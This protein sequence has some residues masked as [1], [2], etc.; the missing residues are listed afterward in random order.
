MVQ[1]PFQ[2]TTTAWSISSKFSPRSSR[3]FWKFLR[4][5]FRY[6]LHLYIHKPD[7]V[8]QMMS[9]PSFRPLDDHVSTIVTN[10]YF[11]G[12]MGR[13]TRRFHLVLFHSETLFMSTLLLYHIFLLRTEC[14]S[15]III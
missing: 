2:L 12:V 6:I 15:A 10:G 5:E 7:V 13:P 4:S 11:L 3:N 1:L 14:L 8:I 9:L